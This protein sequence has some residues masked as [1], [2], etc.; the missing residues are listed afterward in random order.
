MTAPRLKIILD[1]LSEIAAETCVVWPLHP[2]TKAALIRERLL[3]RNVTRRFGLL[4]PLDIWTLISLEKHA[5]L[6]AT[7]SGGVQKEAFFY[8][9]PCV[10]SAR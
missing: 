5:R 1:A 3:D 10:T 4:I 8:Q 2:R 6:I 9:V 7:D